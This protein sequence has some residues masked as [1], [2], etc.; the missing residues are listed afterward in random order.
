MSR[1]RFML[2]SGGFKLVQ[3]NELYNFQFRLTSSYPAI[4][5][6]YTLN[7]INYLYSFCPYINSLAYNGIEVLYHELTSGI[8]L[9]MNL[10]NFYNESASISFINGYP[11]L[12]YYITSYERYHFEGYTFSVA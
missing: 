4:H 12:L 2:L 7:V 9:I 1:R 8:S 11:P 6:D 3:S 5:V 10:S